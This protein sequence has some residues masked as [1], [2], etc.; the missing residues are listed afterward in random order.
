MCGLTGFWDKN[1]SLNCAQEKLEAL[2]QTMADQIDH[3]GPDSSGVWCDEKTGIA[4]GH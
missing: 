4:F 1:L 3:R 2:V